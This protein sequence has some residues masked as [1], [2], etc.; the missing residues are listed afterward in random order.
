[1]MPIAPPSAESFLRRSCSKPTRTSRT[2]LPASPSLLP[3]KG[4]SRVNS[5]PSASCTTPRAPSMP[6]RIR[7][8]SLSMP[9]KLNSLRKSSMMF[10]TLGTE[11]L[12]SFWPEIAPAAPP[13]RPAS[14]AA[15]VEAVNLPSEIVPMEKLICIGRSMPKA[16]STA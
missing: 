7:L 2:K 16:P 9:S 14:P 3:I 6:S 11:M 5:D 15:V 8:G 12:S 4:I 10:W 1:M 13:S